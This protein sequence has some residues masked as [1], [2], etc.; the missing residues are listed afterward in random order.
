M[1]LR[2]AATAATRANGSLDLE[3]RQHRRCAVTSLDVAALAAVRGGVVPGAM[4]SAG[5]ALGAAAG[6]LFGGQINTTVQNGDNNT[7]VT[8]SGKGN[9]TIYDNCGGK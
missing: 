2:T 4:A 1:H 6:K 3:Q 5:A 7:N 9:V 8:S